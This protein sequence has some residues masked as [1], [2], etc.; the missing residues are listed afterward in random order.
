MKFVRHK[1]KLPGRSHP[2][3]QSNNHPITTFCIWRLAAS[4]L[5]AAEAEGFS[6]H[7]NALFALAAKVLFQ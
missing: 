1:V 7:A 5:G 4:T 3:S 6:R 2:R